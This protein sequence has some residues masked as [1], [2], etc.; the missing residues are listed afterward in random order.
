VTLRR[1]LIATMVILVA[2]G[3]VAV[4]VVTL[5]ALHSYLYGRAD[6]QLEANSDLVQR[7]VLFTDERGR[8]I[9]VAEIQSRVSPDVYV[10]VLDAG[11][12][13]VVS[14]PSGSRA[15]ADPAPLL[16][17][18]LPV[19]P[20][21]TPDAL[22]RRHGSYNPDA[23]AV[24]VSSTSRHGPLYR[25]RASPLPGGTLVV[26]TR[27]DSVNAT[28]ASLRN[29]ELAVSLGV[30]VA[31]LL[32]M[33][34]LIRRGLKPLEVMTEEADTIAAGDLSRRVVPSDP[35]TEIG[36]LG[37]ALNGML[38]Q[39]EAAFAQRTMSEDR[40]RRFLADA[41]HELRTPL[42]SIRG[43]A[44]LLRKGAYRH[45]ADRQRALTRIESEAARMGD[46]VE[47]L[48]ILA[49][50]GEGPEPER[51]RVDLV[52]VVRDAVTDARAVDPTRTITVHAAAPVPVAGDEPRLGQ[53]IHNLL[54][55]ALTHTPAGTPVTVQVT[56]D[57]GRA[58]LRVA[59][60][61]PGMDV[62]QASRIFDR[63]YRG[64]ATRSDGGSGLGLFIVAAVA[65]GLGGHV[66]V[67]TAVGEG[68][69]FEVVLPLYGSS[70]VDVEPGQP[71]PA[72]PTVTG[73]GPGPGTTG[74]GAQGTSGPG[75]SPANGPPRTPGP[76]SAP[77]P[78]RS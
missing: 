29:I 13:V 34:F 18:P 38:G 24:T 16:P 11:G 2:V 14:R 53:L 64:D 32:L 17:T 39:I 21:A 25:L 49:R 10:E 26:A 37:R 55:N 60:Q 65:R 74:S 7:F 67:E 3:L 69:T 76:T 56:G 30:V 22:S 6:A 41:S 28:L 44:E 20:S 58:V 61:G 19:R 40:L 23:D 47:D 4:D 43:Y 15:Q 63:F 57:R 27:L 45:E 72:A 62:E 59:D 78:G 42:T 8:P 68:A 46:L 1:R 35:D 9:N 73:P 36:R 12:Q 48:L 70:G 54:G 33:T 52:S 31:L 66:T 50:L 71:E 77:V 51:R 5:S 75:S